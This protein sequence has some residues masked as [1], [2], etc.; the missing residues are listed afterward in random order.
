MASAIG[1]AQGVDLNRASP[2]DL[3]RV[4]GLGRERVERL[5][6]GRPYRSWD[7]MERLDGFGD[8]LVEDLK[9]TGTTLGDGQ[10]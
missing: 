8:R 7:E 1:D 9:R 10:D 4:G 3:D 6:E 5:I 2:E